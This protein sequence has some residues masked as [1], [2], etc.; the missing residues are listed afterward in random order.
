MKKIKQIL[1]SIF[2]LAFITGC[3]KDKNEPKET[4][5]KSTISAKWNVSNSSDYDSFE[6]NE[7]G[8]YIVVKNTTTKSTAKSTNDQIILFGTY[9]IIDNKTIILSDFGT[10]IVTKIDENLTS[11]SIKLTSDPNNEII[12]NASKQEEIKSSTRT[13]LLCRT[14][15][16]VT[17][18]GEPVAGTDREGTVL[19]SKAGTYFVS[20]ANDGS[21]GIAQWKWNDDAETQLLY[22]WE[23]VPVFNNDRYVDIPELS[24]TKLIIIEYKQTYI[25]QPVSTSKSVM[26]NSLKNSSNR[27]MKSGFFNK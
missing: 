10:I 24:S 20:K 16:M 26:K 3:D 7:S 14:W 5:D 9:K 2:V 22:S 12:I 21:G 1:A 8:N 13:D 11:F 4:L 6:F 18:N 15:E 27:Q 25:L 17:F 19:F 23:V